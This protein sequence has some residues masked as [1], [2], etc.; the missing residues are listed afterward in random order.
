MGIVAIGNGMSSFS[1]VLGFRLKF[2]RIALLRKSLQL[3]SKSD[4]ITNAM[5]SYCCYMPR[6]VDFMAAW[7]KICKNF[8]NVVLF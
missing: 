6:F 5:T 3:D 8:S 7:I 1:C 4:L 2:S